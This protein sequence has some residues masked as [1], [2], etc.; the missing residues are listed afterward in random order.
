M[1]KK[2]FGTGLA[3]ISILFFIFHLSAAPAW[4]GPN[5]EAGC[6]VDLDLTTTDYDSGVSQK[7]IEASKTVEADEEFW[8]AVVAQNVENLD[9][10]QVE[11]NFDSSKLSFVRAAE[12]NPLQGIDNLLKKNGGTTIGFQAILIADGVVNIADSLIGSSTDEA[13]EGSG[14]IALLQFRALPGISDTQ[15]TPDNVFFL[16]SDT[17]SDSPDNLSSAVIEVETTEKPVVKTFS[18]TP[19]TILEGETSTLSLERH[20]VRR[21]LRST[22]ASD[23]SISN[24]APCRFPPRPPPPIL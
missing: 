14:V 9:T 7:D 19:S 23:R 12:D 8:V 18:A 17:T 24:P 16:D 21:R 20:G 4:S 22:T 15:L 2:T 6:A 11:M 13:P 5:L 3:A 1:D 10:F